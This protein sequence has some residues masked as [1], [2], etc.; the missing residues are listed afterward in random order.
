MNA[1]H[2]QFFAMVKRFFVKS[3]EKTWTTLLICISFAE[4]PYWY[5]FVVGLQIRICI[6]M[7]NRIQIPTEVKIL[8]LWRVKMELSRAVDAHNGGM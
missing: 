7:G 8:E 5:W 1:S 3:S 2:Q 4:R 6:I